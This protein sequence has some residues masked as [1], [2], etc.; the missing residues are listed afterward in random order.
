MSKKQILILKNNGTPEDGA[1]SRTLSY[2]SL[3]RVVRDQI[4]NKLSNRDSAVKHR[5]SEKQVR[6][7]RKQADVLEAA[8]KGDKKKQQ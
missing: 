7:W 5:I 1:G 6:S 2:L 8:V 3:E 4:A